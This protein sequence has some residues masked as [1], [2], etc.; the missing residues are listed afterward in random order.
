M[1]YKFKSN[2]V[3][4][5]GKEELKIIPAPLPD[6]PVNGFIW[7]DSVDNKFKV[8][9]EEKERWLTLGD[10]EDVVF[11]NS[12]N[13]FSSTNVQDAIEEAPNKAKKSGILILCYNASSTDM[14]LGFGDKLVP[15]N[16]SAWSPP[17]DCHITQ[18]QFT[19]KKSGTSSQKTINEIKCHSMSY[20]EDR[21]ITTSDSV[22]WYVNNYSSSKL[23]RESGYGRTWEYDNSSEGDHLYKNTKYAFRIEN[24]A[25]KNPSDVIITLLVEEI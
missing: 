8:Y 13:G 3:I 16:D 18:V 5:Q 9:S 22:A 1:A 19:N 10:A 4:L 7:L 25:G 15:T 20:S 6:N 21:S 12:S 23:I 24:L 17:F 14:W 11:D 2:K